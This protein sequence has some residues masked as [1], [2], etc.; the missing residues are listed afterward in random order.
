MIVTDIQYALE[1][2]LVKK[3]DIMIDRSTR[4]KPKRDAL[5]INH[6]AEGEGK[7]NTS[8]AEAYYI[9]YK[10]GRPI[11]LFFTL[12]PMMRFAQNTEGQI[13]IWDEPSLDSLS[14]DHMSEINKNLLRLFMTIRKKQH[15]FIINMTKFWKFSEYIVVDRSLGMIHLYSR[16]EVEPGRF[17]YIK[18]KM[19]E[20][21]W[22]D[23]RS[24]KIRNFKKYRSFGGR[25][26]EIMEEH[27]DKLGVSVNGIPNATLKIYEHEKDEAIK[28]IGIKKESKYKKIYDLLRIKIGLLKPNKKPITSQEDLAKR[29][30]IS[31]R[32]LEKWAKL[33]KKSDDGEEEEAFSLENPSLRVELEPNIN[34]NGI[35]SEEN[36]AETSEQSLKVPIIASNFEHN[37]L[38]PISNARNFE[39]NRLNEQLN[40]SFKPL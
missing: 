27:F 9:K 11:N 38:K 6:G 32:M 24:K 31:L 19:L 25:F 5:L 13:I 17:I 35:S 8:I 10:T 40:R 21:L 1:D 36:H 16:A 30:N 34:F 26:P 20:N 2:K 22:N 15:F 29:L 37:K 4:K 14:A 28:S 12:E 39:L 3:L 23:Y 18:K 7:T 33:D